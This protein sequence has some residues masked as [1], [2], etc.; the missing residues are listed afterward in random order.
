MTALE[1]GAEIGHACTLSETNSRGW[2]ATCECGWIGPVAPALAFRS[3]NLRRLKYDSDAVRDRAKASHLLHCEEVRAETARQSWDA[4]ER[5][6]AYI[7]K[8]APTIRHMG[9][10][11]RG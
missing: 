6:A 5:N 10:W 8:V 9:R 7:Q 1:L 11:G 2:C 3:K 4:M